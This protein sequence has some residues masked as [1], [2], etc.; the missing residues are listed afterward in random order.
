MSKKISESIILAKS[1][2]MYYAFF[3]LFFLVDFLGGGSVLSSLLGSRCC[4]QTGAPD[5]PG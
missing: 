4:D 1:K 5:G 2:Q 3:F